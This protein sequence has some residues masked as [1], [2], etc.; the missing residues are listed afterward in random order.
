MKTETKKWLKN[1]II[2]VLLALVIT[3]IAYLLFIYVSNSIAG[4]LTPIIF[5]LVLIYLK[6]HNKK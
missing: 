1:D 4:M 3:I 6:L 2:D 5:L